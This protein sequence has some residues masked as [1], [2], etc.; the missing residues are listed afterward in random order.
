M[1]A[2]QEEITALADKAK[3]APVT[4]LCFEREGDPHCHRYSLKAM[5]DAANE[6]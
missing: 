1:S 4:L 3:K 2:R 5:I 6:R